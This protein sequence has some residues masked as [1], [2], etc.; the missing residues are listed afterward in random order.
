M[1]VHTHTQ[2]KSQME[3]LDKN[4]NGGEKSDTISDNQGEYLALLELQNAVD[5][6]HLPL[7]K[8]SGKGLSS[9]AE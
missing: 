7:L 2:N 5:R 1:Y 3:K 4:K 9:E 6:K 8:A